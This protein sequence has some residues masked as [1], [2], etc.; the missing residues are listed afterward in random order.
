MKIIKERTIEDI[1]DKYI[2]HKKFA[3]VIDIIMEKGYEITDIKESGT[4]FQ[5]RINGY[6]LRTLKDWKSNKEWANYLINTYEQAMVL[7]EM[8]NK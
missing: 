4:T 2:G 6:P 7:M 3:K 1:H 5:F 8:Q